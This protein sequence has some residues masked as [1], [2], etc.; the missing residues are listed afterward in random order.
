MNSSLAQLALERLGLVL[1]ELAL[2]LLDERQDVAHAEDPLGHAVGVEALEL[3]ELLAG[4]GEQDRLAG[5]R[6]DATARRRRG[7]RRRAWSS[8]R[9]RSSTASANCSATLTASWPVIASTT[10]RIVC[11]RTAVRM[12]LSSCMSS[13][14]MCRRPGGV[15]DQDV[16][17]VHLGLVERPAGDVD[18]VL[19]GAPLVDGRPGLAADLD[20][21]LDRRRAVDVA[22][23]HGHRGAVLLAQVARE[24]GRRGR[25]ARALQAGHQDDGRRARR[26]RDAR[27]SRRPSARRAPR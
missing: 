2:G 20:E 25:L 23:G 19:V 13:V 14:S 6:L 22:R 1:V 4:G 10:S 17:A 5:D 15:D 27:R 16:L 9:R 24:L 11:G 7:R 18:R 12:S 3:V 26:E 21:L 8:R